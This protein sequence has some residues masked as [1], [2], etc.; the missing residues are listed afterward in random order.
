MASKKVRK[1]RA[2][3]RPQSRVKLPEFWESRLDALAREK[4]QHDDYLFNL[5]EF[6]RDVQRPQDGVS[7]RALQEARQ[8]NNTMTEG[9]FAR[10]SRKIGYNDPADFLAALGA[11]GR[12][13]RT[14]VP[15]S[16]VLRT[17]KT[18][19]QW[20]DWQD[21]DIEPARPWQLRCHV[22]T[23]SPYFRFGFKLISKDGRACG[24]GALISPDPS[25]LVHIGRNNWDRPHLGISQRDLFVAAYKGVATVLEDRCLFEVPT[26]L[27]VRVELAIDRS[28]R[29]TLRVNDAMAFECPVP[30]AICGRVVVCAWGD[31]EEFEVSVS[32]LNVQ[33]SSDVAAL[34]VTKPRATGR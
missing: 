26:D 21:G 14:P 12:R 4:W 6:L 19:P 30:P 17:Q 1:R 15:S 16:F 33:A 10:L 31:R 8:K 5:Y 24:D 11:T 3:K 20:A 7:R 27:G 9:L 18:S 29:A 32:E 13:A 22:A 34:V 28:D 23:K 25:L 2:G